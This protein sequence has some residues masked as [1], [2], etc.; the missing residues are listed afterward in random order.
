MGCEQTGPDSGLTGK[1]K[2]STPERRSQNSSDNHSD[3]DRSSMARPPLAGSFDVRAQAM[4][5]RQPALVPGGLHDEN[6][7]P[8]RN[9]RCAGLET[10]A[11][12]RRGSMET[13]RLGLL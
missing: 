3:K 1:G 6:L 5:A 8:G 2:A 4:P 7:E 12:R 10:F 13:R 11:V 9:T